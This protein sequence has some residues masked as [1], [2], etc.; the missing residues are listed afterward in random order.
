MPSEIKGNI[1]IKNLIGLKKTTTSHTSA[2]VDK[3]KYIYEINLFFVVSSLLI[4]VNFFNVNYL[5]IIINKRT[6]IAV[7]GGF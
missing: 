5:I 7:F 1:M 6:V 3:I 4:K 2:D